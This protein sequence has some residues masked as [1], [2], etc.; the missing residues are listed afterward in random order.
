M[1][2]ELYLSHRLASIAVALTFGAF[3]SASASAAAIKLP[4]C[5]F[6]VDVPNAKPPEVLHT[7]EF[8]YHQVRGRT[9]QV[10]FQAECLPG[11]MN[12]DDAL[13]ASR[14]HTKS[15]AGRGMQFKKISPTVFE[16]RFVKDIMG[17]P[18]TYVV[19]YHLGG[20]S[21]L[22]IAAGTESKNY[23]HD[24]VFQFFKSVR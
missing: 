21:T 23:P 18:M 4:D 15:I 19:R 20:R 1:V 12:G 22:I 24:E 5:E 2:S 10:S 14:A 3:I 6:S 11:V 13:A 17:S 16:N 7:E 9:K 8:S